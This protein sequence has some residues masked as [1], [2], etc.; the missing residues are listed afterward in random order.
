MEYLGLFVHEGRQVDG[1]E[2]A[3]CALICVGVLHDFRAQITRLNGAQVLLVGLRVACILVQ[4]V[5]SASLNLKRK[6]VISATN[7]NEAPRMHA[8]ASSTHLGVQDGHP[9][10]LGI[11][12]LARSFLALVP[13]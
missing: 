10:L 2:V 3:D 9:E 8:N 5:R 13:D 12:Y 6:R 7:K 11:H 1:G 4:H